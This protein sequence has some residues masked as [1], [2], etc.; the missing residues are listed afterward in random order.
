MQRAGERVQ[1]ARGH[2]Y[3]VVV[4]HPL[5]CVRP[6]YYGGVLTAEL[7]DLPRSKLEAVITDN[8]ILARGVRPIRVT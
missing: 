1:Q 8:G 4:K 6:Y 2:R 7:H 5:P 3:P